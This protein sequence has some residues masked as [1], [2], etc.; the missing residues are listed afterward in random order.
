MVVEIVFELFG[1]FLG[2]LA[3]EVLDVVVNVGE[4]DGGVDVPG[5]S[6]HNEEDFGPLKVHPLSFVGFNASVY[7]DFRALHSTI[8]KSLS[9]SLLKK[10]SIY[11]NASHVIKI[12]DFLNDE[13]KKGNRIQILKNQFKIK[14][15]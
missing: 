3:S 2:V 13:I 14:K 12:N 1:E 15:C 10:S 7:F 4:N 6:E 5:L 8:I 11:R 9:I